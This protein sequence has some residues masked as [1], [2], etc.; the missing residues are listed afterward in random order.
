MTDLK[1]ESFEDWPSLPDQATYDK[2]L[3]RH[4]LRMLRL[5]QRIHQEQK[6]AILVFE[7]W[8]AAGKGGAI[9]RLCEALDPRGF[10]VHAISAPS[11][12]EKEHHY[13]WRFW[14][15]L[16]GAGGLAVFDR[17]W[18]GRVLVERVDGLTSV[19]NWQRAYEELNH[20]ERLL[21]DDG[22]ALVKILLHISKAEQA[23][24]FKERK[25]NPFKSWKLTD[26]DWQAHEKYDS[27]YQAT[28]D[29]LRLTNMHYA[30]WTVVSANHKWYTRIRVM[31]AVC[32]A[33]EQQFGPAKK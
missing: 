15:D 27:Y 28:N 18:Y 19:E 8:D 17:S 2:E 6:T 4:Q 16:P 7:G 9:R 29:M 10:S 14:R 20:F 26:A 22:T 12:D 1:L 30:P 32:G 24:R 21:V 13:L 11:E 25:E 5:E 3:K 33:L 23:K 31:D